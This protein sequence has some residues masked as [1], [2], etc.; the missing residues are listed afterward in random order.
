MSNPLRHATARNRAGTPMLHH[1]P[2][3][4]FSLKEGAVYISENYYGVSYRTLESYPD[5]PRRVVNKLR[6]NTQAELDRAAQSRIEQ[7]DARLTAA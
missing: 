4:L 6:R 7:A 5:L 3:K 2:T 1:P